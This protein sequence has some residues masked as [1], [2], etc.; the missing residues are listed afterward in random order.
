MIKNKKREKEIERSYKKLFRALVGLNNIESIFLLEVAKQD[1]LLNE[2]IIIIN[3]EE[4]SGKIMHGVKN[5]FV[6]KEK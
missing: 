5:S 4:N 1:I 6:R 2:N 3:G